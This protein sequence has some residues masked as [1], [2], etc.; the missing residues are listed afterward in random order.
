M[1]VCIHIDKY[2]SQSM[3]T[4]ASSKLSSTTTSMDVHSSSS[5]SSSASTPTTSNE[6]QSLSSTTI[7]TISTIVS[8]QSKAKN[9]LSS[10]IVPNLSGI[11]VPLNNNNNNVMPV[12]QPGQPKPISSIKSVPVPVAA[13]TAIQPNAVAP[14]SATKAKNSTSGS[15]LDTSASFSLPMMDK[16]IM[17]KIQMFQNLFGSLMNKGSGGGKCKPKCAKMK[18]YGKMKMSVMPGLG[19]KQA[20]REVKKYVDENTLAMLLMKAVATSGMSNH[21]H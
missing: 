16:G 12:V 15:D 21:L 1:Y 3:A 9:I 18:G 14:M 10:K 13:S 7:S 19:D 8:P 2:R 5:S 4:A 11:V 20:E 17:G 6:Q